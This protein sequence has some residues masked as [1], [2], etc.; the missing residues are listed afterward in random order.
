MPLLP[1]GNKAPAFG[2]NGTKRAR[3]FRGVRF[4]IFVVMIA[5]ALRMAL[6]G[7]FIVCFR[8]EVKSM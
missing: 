2:E 8:S 4:V 1:S 7:A 5:Y 6:P 3:A